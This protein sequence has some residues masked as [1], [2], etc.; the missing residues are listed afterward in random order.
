MS[1]EANSNGGGL[2]KPGINLAKLKNQFLILSPRRRNL[3]ILTIVIVLAIAFVYAFR[4]KTPKIAP[5]NAAVLTVLKGGKFTDAQKILINAIN[6]TNDK[7][8]KADLYLQKSSLELSNNHIIDAMNSAKSAESLFPSSSSANSIAEVAK[9]ERD[10]PLAIKWY[11]IAITRL[12]KTTQ[13]YQAAVQELQ[14]NIQDL[15]Q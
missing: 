6:S 7:Q 1:N 8:T 15:S 5:Y 3:L 12:D 4:A 10:T 14:A 11:K 13:G 9:Y 2:T